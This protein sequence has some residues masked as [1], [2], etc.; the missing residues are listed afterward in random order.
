[1][2]VTPESAYVIRLSARDAAVL[3][4]ILNTI[5]V[6]DATPAGDEAET[7]AGELFESLSALGA[8]ADLSP[9]VITLHHEVC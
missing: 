5:E 9:L 1:M 8:K 6:M 2:R 7:L 4:N 3:M